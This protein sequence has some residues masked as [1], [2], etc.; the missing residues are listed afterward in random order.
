M[1]EQENSEVDEEKRARGG[2]RTFESKSPK[3]AQASKSKRRAKRALAETPEPAQAE[4][5]FYNQER[6]SE[7]YN[8]R[9]R[10]EEAARDVADGTITLEE[11]D[12]A[13][14]DAV[15]A[16][17]I[18]LAGQG[19]FYNPPEQPAVIE[20]NI[21]A[22]NR[23]ARAIAVRRE[24]TAALMRNAKPLPSTDINPEVLNSSVGSSDPSS[25]IAE[26]QQLLA[27]TPH[28]AAM[29][30]SRATE[31]PGSV[32]TTVGAYTLLQSYASPHSVAQSTHGKRSA[33]CP[34]GYI[35]SS[36]HT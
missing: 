17:N 1:A 34:Q 13:L 5:S 7:V 14:Y 2:K 8:R 12:K 23:L 25:P 24:R 11:L 21:E 35:T 30:P 22:L 16:R 10:L 18:R 19:A 26:P 20:L 33:V 31:L 36:E 4:N 6:H 3:L 9:S 28:F 15:T 29:T 32:Q 27:P